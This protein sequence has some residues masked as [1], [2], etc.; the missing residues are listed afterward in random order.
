[1]RLGPPQLGGD[2]ASLRLDLVSL[3]WVKDVL[4]C[5][6]L[7]ITLAFRGKLHNHHFFIFRDL[8]QRLF[9]GASSTWRR[10][11]TLKTSNL[12]IRTARVRHASSIR[13][14]IYIHWWHVRLPLVRWSLCIMF[15]TRYAKDEV[16]KVCQYTVEPPL[17]D[18]SA[19]MLP[20][21]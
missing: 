15:N 12:L 10:N 11:H 13:G 8:A 6:A 20:L 14:L 3:V 16:A 4:N 21:F 7:P 18:T 17:A 2:I 9:R 5:Q 1:M 19:S